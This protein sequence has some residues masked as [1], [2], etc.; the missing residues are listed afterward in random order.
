MMTRRE[1]GGG[2]RGERGEKKREG[3]MS[4]KRER[5]SE[6]MG[7]LWQSVGVSSGLSW[8]PALPEY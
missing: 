1:R 3:E 8:E 4:L 7:D 6:S 5:Q 2:G